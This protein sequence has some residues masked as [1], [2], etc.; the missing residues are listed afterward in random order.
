[1]TMARRGKRLLGISATVLALMSVA[2]PAPA[3]E[4]CAAE[5]CVHAQRPKKDKP[6]DGLLDKVGLGSLEDIP[7]STMPLAL[8]LSALI[9]VAGGFVYSGLTGSPPVRREKGPD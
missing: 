6:D 3:N 5:S 1:M 2:P 9:G 4:A 8:G 7:W